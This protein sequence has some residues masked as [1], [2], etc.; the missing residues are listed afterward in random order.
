MPS[1]YEAL[2]RADRVAAVDELI[3]R[4]LAKSGAPNKI[5]LEK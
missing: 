2:S 5:D 1:K 4:T 3:D